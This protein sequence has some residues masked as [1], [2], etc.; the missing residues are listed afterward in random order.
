MTHPSRSRGKNHTLLALP[1]LFASSHVI[2]A[3]AIGAN[4]SERNT[5]F[6]EKVRNFYNAMPSVVAADCPAGKVWTLPVA[7]G[8]AQ[9]TNPIAASPAG[10]AGYYYSE[11][12]GG[13]AS[14]SAAPDAPS[15]DCGPAGAGCDAAS[16]GAADSG[17]AGDAGGAGDAGDAG[18][19]GDAG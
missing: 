9:C 16:A 12:N 2:A 5:A 18:D 13:D 7:G 19:G 14:A 10:D 15:P 8:I 1:L 6:R 11:V 4:D 3:G 17:S